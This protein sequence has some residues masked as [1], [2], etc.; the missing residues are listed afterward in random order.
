M[1]Q[2]DRKRLV[3]VVV[4]AEHPN[5]TE[6]AGNGTAVAVV[7]E[8]DS[9]LGG[10]VSARSDFLTGGLHVRQGRIQQ[11]LRVKLQVNRKD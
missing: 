9:I 11:V 8:N 2:R 1:D 7:V 10:F 6:V 4:L 3:F 5:L